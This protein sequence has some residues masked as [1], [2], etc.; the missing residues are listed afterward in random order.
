[1]ED[2]GIVSGSQN[3]SRVLENKIN[4]EVLKALLESRILANHA[5]LHESQEGLCVFRVLKWGSVLK[6]MWSIIKAS[7]RVRS[8]SRDGPRVSLVARIFHG[9]SHARNER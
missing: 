1:M 9:F 8:R 2:N 5:C 4:E 7:F 6:L 3:E